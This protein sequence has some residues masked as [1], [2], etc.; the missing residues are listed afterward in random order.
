MSL[1]NAPGLPGRHLWA[2]ATGL[3]LA[4]SVAPVYAQSEAAS[5]AAEAGVE[6][7]IKAIKSDI[8][9]IKR[10]LR[11]ILQQL[12]RRPPAAQAAPTIAKVSVADQPYLGRQDALVTLVEF[13][14]YQCP[15]CRRFM[16]NTLP[17]LKTEYID[18][19]KLKYVF[20]DLPLD[21]IHPYARK[22]SEAAHCA[23]DQGQYWAMHDVIFENQKAVQVENLKQYARGIGG[24]DAEAFDACLDG[25]KYADKVA[26]N[27]AD[28]QQAGVRGTPG[29]FVGKTQQDGW[30]TGESIRGARPYGVFHQAIEKLLKQKPPGGTRGGG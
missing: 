5:A 1:I 30:I 14:D 11:A 3:V 24:I 27:L 17:R 2:A 22:A 4:V 28:G 25:G 26:K 7:D 8:A 21:R 23:G 20:R 18:T 13:S 16:K 12:A 10:Q 29:F 6:D 9:E 15:F 19:G